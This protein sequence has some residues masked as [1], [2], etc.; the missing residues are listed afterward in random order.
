MDWHIVFEFLILVAIITLVGC[1]LKACLKTTI[2]KK[3]YQNRFVYLKNRLR[4]ETKKSK[5]IHQKIIL[6]DN[7]NMALHNRIPEI[8]NKFISFQKLIFEERPL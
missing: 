1:V 5:L 4:R 8:I 3:T 7:L 6:V 2:L